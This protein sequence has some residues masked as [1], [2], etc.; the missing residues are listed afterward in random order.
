[1]RRDAR[2][3]RKARTAPFASGGRFPRP[4]GRRLGFRLAAA[5]LLAACGPPAHDSYDSD[6]DGHFDQED[7][8]PDDA[9][10]FS[11]AP[12]AVGDG[13]D[14]N[15]D[16]S[17]GVD[18]DLDG[19]ARCE[20][21]SGDDD[22]A[23][24]LDCDCNDADPLV[25]PGATEIPDN[26]TDEDCDGVAVV[27]DADG[28]GIDALGCGG[29][30]CD[31]RDAGC[32]ST[33]DCL[34][35]DGDGARRCDLD[36]ADLDPER[37]PGRP[38]LCDGLDNDCLDGVPQDEIDADGDGR[39]ACLDDCLE[40]DPSVPGAI[41]VCDGL[42][43]DC[44]PLTMLLE[45]D[46]DGDQDPACRDCDDGDPSVDTLDRDGDLVTRCDGD[47]DDI[48][49]SVRPGGLDPYGDGADGNC[50]GIDGV[51]ADGDGFSALGT[52]CDDNDAGC[53]AG[54]SCLD[55]DSDGFRG[56][57]GDCDDTR[58][59]VHPG[60]LLE[61]CG[62]AD[63]DCDGTLPPDEVDGDGDGDPLCSDCDD[64]NMVLSTLD[65]DGDF[66]SSCGTDCDD[67]VAQTHPGAPDGF[68]DGVDSNCD[69]QDGV[70]G[71]GDARVLGYDDCD[72]ADA[73]CGAASTC[74]DADND[75]FRVCDGD[76]ADGQPAVNP[77]ATVE[78]CD[79]FDG[80]CV[81]GLPGDEVDLDLDGDPACTDCDD[82]AFLRS[83]QDRDG[84]LQ[85]G[86][87]T[88][89][90]DF[91]DRIRVGA[92]DG[93]GD[94]SDDNC[95][96]ID[97]VDADGDGLALLFGDCDDTNP[98]CGAAATCA[99]A[100]TDGY[101]VCDGDCRD[102]V[103]SAH[104]GGDD[105]T[106]CDGA[107]SDCD[108]DLPVAEIDSDGDGDPA[109]SDCDDTDAIL[110]TFDLDGDSFSTCE[111]DCDDDNAILD[112][113]DRDLDG[114]TP[115][116]GDC[117][118]YNP[119][120]NPLAQEACDGLDN[121]CDSI[122]P[123][124]EADADLDGFALCE[125]DCDDANALVYPTRVENVCDGLDADCVA[126]PLEVDDDGDGSMECAG[127]CDDTDP[128]VE[129]LDVDGDGQSTCGT[130]CIVNNVA[131]RCLVDCDDE[132]PNTGAAFAEVCD[133][134]DNSCDG[135][136]PNTVLIGEYDDDGD[137]YV[138]CEPWIGAVVTVTG[139]NDCDDG[140]TLWN[141]S[142]TDVCDGLDTN[143]NG[144][145]D[146]NNDYDGDGYCAG[147]CND[148]DP[149]IHPGLWTDLVG[150][151][152]D[153]DCGGIDGYVVDGAFGSTILGPYIGSYFGWT[154]VSMRDVTGD[155]IDDFAQVDTGNTTPQTGATSHIRIFAGRVSGDPT[156]PYTNVWSL[157][158]FDY[159]MEY[160]GLR[161]LPDVDGDGSRDL[162][163]M[164][165]NYGMGDIWIFSPAA[166][167]SYTL[168]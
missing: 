8:D 85:T 103:A 16:G 12:D 125:A 155:A 90:N 45:E 99:D 3:P 73:A 53:T 1:M 74:L 61:I 7:C 128:L 157:S 39:L 36:C 37:T 59:G 20:N 21:G 148:F 91:D 4:L 161:S 120:Y 104:P 30:D 158:T 46:A 29:A 76:C 55:A 75:G 2:A 96:G 67:L 60:A 133:Q 33:D 66:D 134:L 108:G 132:N 139:G 72:D 50:D 121:D 49:P 111:G 141:P 163:A 112:L 62:G 56:C 140:S 94:G 43:S 25:N 42:D 131:T 77:G 24:G 40:G 123:P 31:D 47:C 48:E 6:G 38:E 144:L 129:G 44:D 87:G 5:L 68:G 147:D 102:D 114:A 149:A 100:D 160:A 105:T 119:I 150:D 126:D 101:R 54:P 52:D 109:C 136:I 138:E 15:C 166:W 34:D 146:D 152:V 122:V 81:G 89:C 41:E 27:C 83:S 63:T 115:C 165:N 9:A 86:C 124:N 162:G 69:G 80:D 130:A 14:T 58:T 159:G 23:Q 153:Q 98:L 164:Q 107:D 19:A 84:D 51:D 137:G 18:G 168:L 93:Y 142:V 97:G 118:D 70:D 26:E 35:E 10:V 116:D 22:S 106:G 167:P 13:L 127:D 143:C 57:D 135:A 64:T 78:L 71:D 92:P 28:D 110:A 32:S 65:I 156:T 151:G 17:D 79:G 82:N 11:G 154:T 117:S 88:D 113:M 145:P 95:D